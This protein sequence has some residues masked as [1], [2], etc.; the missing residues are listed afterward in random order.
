MIFD[1]PQSKKVRTVVIVLLVLTF[2]IW[3]G[4]VG[5]L[6]GLI[7][8]LIA[9]AFGLVAGLIGGIFGAIGGMIGAIFDVIFSPWNG[10][11]FH[12]VNAFW[13]AIGLIILVMIARSRRAAR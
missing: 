12:H 4:I 7:I 8:G 9:G 11:H 5:G 3:I 6:F 10:W 1:I 13:F 2:P